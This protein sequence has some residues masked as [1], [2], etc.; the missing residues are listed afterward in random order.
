VFNVN[1]KKLSKTETTL[2]NYKFIICS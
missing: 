2:L 1:L